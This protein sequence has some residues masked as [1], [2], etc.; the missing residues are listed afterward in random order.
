MQE[1]SR[2]IDESGHVDDGIHLLESA[3]TTRSPH[4][5]LSDDELDMEDME[6]PQGTITELMERLNQGA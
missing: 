4:A 1:E 3:G 6:D 5:E 2:R